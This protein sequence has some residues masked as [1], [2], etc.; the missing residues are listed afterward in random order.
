MKYRRLIALT[1]VAASAT[2]TLAACGSRPADSQ[3]AAAGNPKYSACMI[4]STGGI[5]DKSFNASA[6]AGLQDVKKKG[7]AKVS[8]VQS[9]SEADYATNLSNLSNGSCDLVITV[10][11]LMSE[12]TQNAAKANPKQH[13]LQVDAEGN[14][15][16]LQGMK[17]DAVQSGFLGG[18]L[19]AATSK[20]HTVATYGGLDIV[21]VTDL[22]NGFAEGVKYYNSQ[23]H[24]SVKVL[25]W[26]GATHNGVF[27][28]GFS[29]QTKGQ[30]IGQNFLAQGADVIFPVAGNLGIG[31]A[32]VV[33]QA[34]GDA[35]V[36]WV[37]TDG[38]VSAEQYCKVFLSSVTKNIDNAV[39]EIVAN[40]AAG[41]WSKTDYVGSLSN[42]GV[43]LA[44][45]HDFDS[46]V[47]EKVKSELKQIR[48]D[49]ISGS[50]KIQG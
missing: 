19:A 28:G 9:K 18:Y 32:S 49:I 4:T 2:L 22:M 14:G 43:G 36:L 29:D 26:D 3:A 48:S 40:D 35:S 17:F 6:W 5:D 8:Y 44:P 23:N 42:D 34:G 1:A 27:G 41:K 38:C 25:G 24:A 20:S 31:T 12:A 15:N 37:D 10:G 50:I 33:Q 46:K 7:I 30:Q 11:G 45:F 13:Y 39:S 16:N 47:S 21:P